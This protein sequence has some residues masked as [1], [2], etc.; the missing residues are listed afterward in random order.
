MWGGEASELLV[1]EGYWIA[2][3]AKPLHIVDE[4]FCSIP[5]NGANFCYLDHLTSRA[6][7]AR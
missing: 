5:A 6:S 1:A 7:A 4:T 2:V 3:G